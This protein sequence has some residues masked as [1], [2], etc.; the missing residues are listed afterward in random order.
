MNDFRIAWRNI[1]R[2]RA[3]T[4]I[5]LST[6]AICTSILMLVFGLFL[7]LSQQ[8]ERSVTSMGVGNAQVHA[9][10]YL[11]EPSLWNIVGNAGAIMADAAQ[12]KVRAAPRGIGSALLCLG[13]KTT[14]A[15]VHGINPSAEQRVSRL[16]SH[17]GSGKYLDG[18]VSKGIV[19]GCKLARALD[20]KVGSKLVALTQAA[21]GTTGNDIF[22]VVGILNP[23]GAVPDRSH[24]YILGRDF[25]NL[26]A[27]KHAVHEIAFVVPE[28]LEARRFAERI[29]A[30]FPQVEAL[31]W[32][33]L[34]PAVA[35]A[36][37]VFDASIWFPAALFLLAAT[38]GILNTILMATYERVPE[39]GMIRSLG[40]SPWRIV[41]DIATEGLVLGVLAT[42]IGGALGAG[43]C[44]FGSV[45]GFDFG[46]SQPLE[47]SGIVVDP[48]IHIKVTLPVIGFP[49]AS[50]WFVSL[51]ASLYPALK[52]AHL[53]PIEAMRHI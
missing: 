19:I 24:A 49:I 11:S 53:N 16:P 10:G 38:L 17:I 26:F 33:R 50:M 15:L 20:A 48:I 35:D 7:G 29:S 8:L 30:R 28:Q 3:R 39:F 6:M 9:R 12:T 51:L 27:L 46:S 52:A 18:K 45:N 31:P 23:V 43:L 40:A 21:D 32:Q 14:G 5:C 37:A 36:V 44:Y 2:N 13:E 22:T 1:W 4:V 25:D 34:Q 42:L 41:R 47:L